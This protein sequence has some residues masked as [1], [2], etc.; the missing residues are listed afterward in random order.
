MRPPRTIAMRIPLPALDVADPTAPKMPVPMIIAAVIRVAVLR[1]ACGRAKFL[2]QPFQIVGPIRLPKELDPCS[3]SSYAPHPHHVRRIIEHWSAA[4]QH[5][6]EL[7]LRLL[8]T[9]RKP[10]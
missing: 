10:S 2:I 3:F 5:S 1:L 8:A 7:N 6:S 9:S 4:T